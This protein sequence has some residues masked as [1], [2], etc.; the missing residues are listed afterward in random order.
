[1]ELEYI[2]LTE[3]L[4]RNIPLK[5]GDYLYKHD[6]NEYPLKNEYDI[7]NLFFVTESN[8]HKLTIHNMSNS[9]IEQVDLS[10]T[11]EIWWLLPLPNLIRKQ[12]GLE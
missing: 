2:N 3:F 12:I 10:S 7:S 5:K 8:G 9:N 1:M 11:S 6:K 4:N